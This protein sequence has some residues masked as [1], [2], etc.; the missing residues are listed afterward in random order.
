MLSM[1]ETDLNFTPKNTRARSSKCLIDVNQ[2]PGVAV[3]AWIRTCPLNC[4]ESIEMYSISAKI[5]YYFFSFFD[6]TFDRS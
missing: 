4:I 2:H 6:Y 3:A 5:V 1:H